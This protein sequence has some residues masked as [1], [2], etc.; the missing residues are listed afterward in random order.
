M[1]IS[2]Y[3]D[4]N[5]LLNLLCILVD[6]RSERAGGTEY[7]LWEVPEGIFY[8]RRCKLKVQVVKTLGS[9]MLTLKSPTNHIHTFLFFTLLV[10]CKFTDIK[11]VMNFKYLQA[12]ITSNR[13]LQA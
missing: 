5:I 7:T 11:Q 2:T 9:A 10:N 3:T 1:E 12:E 13:G 8:C 6:F 4:V